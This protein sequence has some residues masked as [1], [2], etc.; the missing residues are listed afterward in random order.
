MSQ[1]TIVIQI[2]NSD[3]KLT[4]SEW[5][6]F[7]EDVQAT[8]NSYNFETHFFGAPVNYAPWQNVAWVLIVDGDFENPFKMQ[9]IELKERYRQGSIAWTAGHTIFI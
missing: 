8:I 9:L 3:D 4:Q 1:Q 2:G 5:A 7:V 6:S